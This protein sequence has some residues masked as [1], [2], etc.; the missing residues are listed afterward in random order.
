VGWAGVSGAWQIATGGEDFV[1][2]FSKGP[3]FAYHRREERHSNFVTAARGSPDGGAMVSAGMDGLIAA[4]DGKTSEFK[5]E[6]ESPAGKSGSVWALAWSPDGSKVVSGGGDKS[7]RIWS[8][9]GSQVGS[10]VVGKDAGDMQVGVSWLEQGPVSVALDGTLRK[11]DAS[12][13]ALGELQGTQGSVNA[14]SYDKV[15]GTYLWG[16][17]CQSVGLATASAFQTGAGLKRVKL[18]TS[19]AQVLGRQEQGAAGCVASTQD[20][21]MWVIDPAAATVVKELK[22]DVG[23]AVGLE[24]LSSAQVVV[25]TRKKVLAGFDVGGGISEAWRIHLPGEPTALAATSTK[26]GTFVAVTIAFE[27]V[28]T[29]KKVAR[30]IHIYN[31]EGSTAKPLV[32]LEHHVADVTALSFT[33]DGLRLASGDGERKLATWN[34]D[35]ESW[36][37]GHTGWSSSHTARISCL[38]WAVDGCNLVSGSLDRHVQVW[39]AGE[40]SARLKV[41]DVHKG[42]VNSICFD[43]KK[44]LVTGGADGCLKLYQLA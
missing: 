24:W 9:T 41:E 27:G 11:W 36:Q 38:G 10:A 16:A 7:V 29:A 26:A 13:A 33:S 23:S 5:A 44:A 43:D 40:T 42:G 22:A 35:G 4:Y 31:V 14:V 32:Q 8:P 30:P 21:T 6:F 17:S 2:S 20:G 37:L 25:A 28:V 12:C 3:P 18:R 39:N 15:S 19:V 1:V 34:F